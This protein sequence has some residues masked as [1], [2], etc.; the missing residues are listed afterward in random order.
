MTLTRQCGGGPSHAAAARQFRTD[1]IWDGVDV[2]SVDMPP[3]TRDVSLAVFQPIPVDGIVIVAS[4]QEPASMIAGKAVKM[5]GMMNMPIPGIFENMSYFTC[6]DN[7]KG[8]KIFGESHIEDA[9]AKYVLKVL[10]RL[11]IGPGIA[12]ACDEGLI[13]HH[14]DSLFYPVAE[15]IPEGLK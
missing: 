4:P 3:G 7:K 10:G 11:P 15:R 6:P 13:E 9:A 12:A 5:A 1:V 2:M 8:Y 14:G